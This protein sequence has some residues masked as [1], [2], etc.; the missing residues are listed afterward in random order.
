MEN[1]KSALLETDREF[2]EFSVN[3]GAAEAFNKY[4]QDEA[5][6]LPAG[7]L[8]IRG[9]EN[10]YN[11]MLE[12]NQ[13]YILSWEPQDAEVAA[14]GDMGWSWG[15]YTITFQT[16]K[17]ETSRQGKYLNVWKKDAEGNWRVLIDMG[18]QNP[19]DD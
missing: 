11:S 9:R 4:L 19:A 13:E 2:S 17:G 3:H 18:N 16:E 6:Q 12:G 10:I 5:F 1:E 8:P 15:I 14:S 7:R